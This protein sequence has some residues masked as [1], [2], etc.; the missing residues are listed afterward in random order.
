MAVRENSPATRRVAPTANPIV[1]KAALGAAGTQ[2][3]ALS[4]RQGSSVIRGLSEGAFSRLLGIQTTP[5][6]RRALNRARFGASLPPSKSGIQQAPRRTITETP[7]QVAAKAARQRKVDRDVAASERRRV[8][9]TEAQNAQRLREGKAPIRVTPAATRATTP[10]RRATDREAGIHGIPVAGEPDFFEQ[11]FTGPLPGAQER[12]LPF[13]VS[14]P[15]IPGFPGSIEAIT[16]ADMQR[17]LEEAGIR[18]APKKGTNVAARRAAD[19]YA[20]FFS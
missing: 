20:I 10:G 17:I 2:G 3:G 12:A 4:Q 7:A 8:A 6:A 16:G 9:D 14:A 1:S 19:P 15:P 11:N 13:G 5:A 18:V